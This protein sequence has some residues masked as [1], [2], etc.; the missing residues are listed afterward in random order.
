MN[1]Q[2]EIKDLKIR[3]DKIEKDNKILKDTLEKTLKML[4]VKSVRY[5]M[6]LIKSNL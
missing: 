2:E 6:N 4:D 3:L 5:I 1:Y